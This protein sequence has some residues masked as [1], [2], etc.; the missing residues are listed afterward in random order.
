MLQGITFAYKS[1]IVKVFEYKK[2]NFQLQT[3]C[4]TDPESEF[5]LLLSANT[6]MPLSPHRMPV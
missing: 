2:I 6:D 5:S 4:L 3:I 1:E